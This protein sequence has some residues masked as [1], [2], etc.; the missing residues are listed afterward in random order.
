[1]QTLSGERKIQDFRRA[2]FMAK[3]RSLT[4]IIFCLFLFHSTPFVVPAVAS[5]KKSDNLLDCDIHEGPCTKSLQDVIVTLDIKPK[6]VKAMSNL[7]FRVTLSGKQPAS[8]P[9]IDLDM[10]GMRMGRNQVTLK[11]TGEGAYEGTGIIVR[12]P[13]GRRVWRATVIIPDLG[14]VGFTFDVVY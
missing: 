7:G 12:C 1:M 11:A 4:M 13:S 2:P 3:K 8:S 5:G 9:V 14:S 10:P 6:P